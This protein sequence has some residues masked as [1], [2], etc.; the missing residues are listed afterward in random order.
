[1]ES[2][3]PRPDT[4]DVAQRMQRD[5]LFV[6]QS[7][8]VVQMCAIQQWDWSQ[9]RFAVGGVCHDFA[10]D[11]YLFF[12]SFP[13]SSLCSDQV[14]A[15]AFSLL[16]ADGGTFQ[17]FLSTILHVK[18]DGH[19]CTNGSRSKSILGHESGRGFKSSEIFTKTHR[20]SHCCV[21]RSHLSALG[22]CCANLTTAL[23]E[24]LVG[25]RIFQWSFTQAQ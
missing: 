5:A 21:L 12:F 24:E 18:S 6:S 7:R 23:W 15:T 2:R 8:L 3:D 16:S 4:P 25:Q 20:A 11:F 14:T 1:M 9:W 22:F 10:A 17:G 19:W 13:P